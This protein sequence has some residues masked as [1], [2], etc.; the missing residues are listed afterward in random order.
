MLYVWINKDGT[1]CI[2]YD[3]AYVPDGVE[4][5]EFSDLDILDADKLKIENGKI[6]RKT[7]E[8]VLNELKN[9][10]LKELDRIFASQIAQTDYVITKI[11]EAQIVGQDITPLLQQYK[12]KIQWRQAL[13]EWRDIKQK[14]ILSAKNKKELE[15]VSLEDYPK[16]EE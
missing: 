11:Q 12:L 10:M 8:E 5:V 14:V 16:L 15:K 6:V 2:T 13:R 4:Y 3:L 7:D 9:A 1:L